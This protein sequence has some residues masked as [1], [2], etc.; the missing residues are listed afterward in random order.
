MTTR[1]RVYETLGP[2]RRTTAEAA[3]RSGDPRQIRY[4]I[5][6]M[7]LNTPHW[8]L[9]QEAALAHIHHPDLWVRRNATTSLLHVARLTGQLDLDRAVPALLLLLTDP[10]VYGEADDAL[11][12]IEHCLGINR[13]EWMGDPRIRSVAYSHDEQVAEVELAD[14][15]VHRYAG[16]DPFAYRDLWTAAHGTGALPDLLAGLG[17]YPRRK[18]RAPRLTRRRV[19]KAS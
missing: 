8:D 18:L 6:R 1:R 16:I 14:G 2:I 7:A 5:L 9:A 12:S 17:A 15:T 11:D 10:E 13:G 3:L 4:A 19:L